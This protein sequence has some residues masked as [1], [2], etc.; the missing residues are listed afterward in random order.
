MTLMNF[1]RKQLA[2][3]RS[4]A[5]SGDDSCFDCRAEALSIKP[6]QIMAVLE[7]HAKSGAADCHAHQCLMIA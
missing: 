3:R 6:S 5:H 7:M 2:R 1:S 4:P